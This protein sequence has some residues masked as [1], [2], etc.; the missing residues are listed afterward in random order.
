MTSVLNGMGY[1]NG[2][3]PIGIQLRNTQRD[4]E[5]TKADLKMLLGVLEQKAPDVYHE[6]KRLKDEQE[7]RAAMDRARAA[8]EA[9]RAAMQNAYYGNGNRR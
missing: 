2:S 3:N 4:L 7:E 6:Y 5:S 9:R 1:Q 8:E